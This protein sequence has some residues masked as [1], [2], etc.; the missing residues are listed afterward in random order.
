M[1]RETLED[2]P[3]FELP[4]SYTLRWYQSGDEANWVAIHNAADPSNHYSLEKF[5]REFEADRALLSSQQAYLCDGDGL[6]VGTATAWSYQV[7][8][9]EFGLVH[10]V[11][12]HPTSQGRGLAKPLLSLICN[13]LHELGHRHAYLNT[14]TGR[15]PAIALYLKF[16]FVPHSRGDDMAARR[17]WRQVREHLAHPAVDMFL[18]R[19]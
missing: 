5:A 2:L 14:S 17:A 8:Q 1:I 4:A 19:N 15:I 18:N 12:V 7:G 11:A 9:T 6:P 3:N 13:R 16:G 10:W